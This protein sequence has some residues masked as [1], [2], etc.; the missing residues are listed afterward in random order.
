MTIH[1]TN[2]QAH[3]SGHLMTAQEQSVCKQIAMGEGSH[4]QHAVMLLAL[5]GG[6]TKVQAAKGTGLTTG[7]VKYWMTRFQKQ[8]LA[9]FPGALLGKGAAEA[10]AAE[11]KATKKKSKDKRTKKG[12]K[13]GEQSKK[14]GKTSAKAEKKK[15]KKTKKGKKKTGK[16][17]KK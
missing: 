15:S 14:A 4:S 7:Q 13:A 12:K 8:R 10:D 17:K 3:L 5:N 11:T 1:K 6:S 16:G 9:I 2:E